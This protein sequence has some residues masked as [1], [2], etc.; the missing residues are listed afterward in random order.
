M[1]RLLASWTLA[2]V[3]AVLMNR[4]SVQRFEIERLKEELA[5]AREDFDRH[6]RAH[7]N[8]PFWYEANA[9]CYSDEYIRDMV[10]GGEWDRRVREERGK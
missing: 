7:Q 1:L 3:V 2:V 4:V 9:I 6:L 10:F 5:S 8:K